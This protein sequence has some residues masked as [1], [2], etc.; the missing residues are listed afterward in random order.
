MKRKTIFISYANE[1]M[2]YSLKR[3]GRQARRLGIFDEVILYTPDDLPQYVK[4]TNLLGYARGGGF[5][6]WKPAVIYETLQKH[7]EGDIVVWVDAGCTLR[8]STEWRILLGLMEQYDTVCFQYEDKEFPEWEKFGTSSP[9]E[10]YWTKKYTLDCL[11]R[12]LHYEKI[13]DIPQIMTT[14]IFMKGK[15]NTVL[16]EWKNLIINDPDLV[17]D[18]SEDE[19]KEQHPE[20]IRH[21]HDQSVFT[22]LAALDKTAI[23]V[24]EVFERYDKHSFVWASRIRAK[25]FRQFVSIQIKHYLRLCLGND[26]IDRIKRPFIK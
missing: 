17:K 19:M 2:A 21:R 8:K 11:G 16:N 6:C 18:P 13:K 20:Y 3:I 24:P 25:D 23:A 14:V 26:F 7:N 4:D 10:G 5:M 22:P 12:H 1:A 15:A 9:R